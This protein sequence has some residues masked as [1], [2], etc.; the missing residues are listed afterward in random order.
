MKIMNANVTDKSVEE[1]AQQLKSVWNSDD[2]MVNHPPHYTDGGIEVIDFI[3]A[4]NLDFC[5]GNAVKY[6]SRSGKKTDAG[7]TDK[8]KT[9]QDLEKAIWYCKKEIEWLRSE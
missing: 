6:I 5:L 3:K 2:D 7:M 4:K 9:I 1:V 8:A